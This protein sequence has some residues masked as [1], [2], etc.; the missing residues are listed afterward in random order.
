MSN[1][2]NPGPNPLHPPHLPEAPGWPLHPAMIT[3]ALE[4]P[5]FVIVRS[6]GV[7]RGLTVRAVGIGGGITA[8]FQALGGGNVQTMV[9]MCER[10]RQDAFLIM[11]QHAAAFQANA[12][13]GFRYD[14]TEVAQGMTEV[15]AY[16]T[17]VRAELIERR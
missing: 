13:V 17:A 8:S 11:L 7:V 6:Y 1:V 12:V 16:G 3:S 2:P 5:G 4:L 10:A 14:T 9:D 15:L